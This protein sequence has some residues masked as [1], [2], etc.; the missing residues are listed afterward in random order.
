M[1]CLACESSNRLH[2]YQDDPWG[3]HGPR[4]IQQNSERQAVFLH[5]MWLHPPSFSIVTF[6]IIGMRVK[7][8]IVNTNVTL[9]TFLRVCI[10]PI[11]RLTVIIALLQ[12]QFEQ[13]ATYS[14]HLN[15]N[16]LIVSSL[17]L[18]AINRFVPFMSTF[19]TESTLASTFDNSCLAMRHLDSFSTISCRTPSK[20]TITLDETIDGKTSECICYDIILSNQRYHMSVKYSSLS[21]N[22]TIPILTHRL[23]AVYI[24][25]T[26]IRSSKYY[27]RAPTINT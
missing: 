19:E 8:I 1:T 11:A 2:E 17:Y 10:N 16:S 26:D 20:K 5:V 4:H 12:P 27:P 7:W 24:P 15:L 9:G 18:P 22:P 13:S 3:S 25:G 14:S 21:F 23:L 6:I